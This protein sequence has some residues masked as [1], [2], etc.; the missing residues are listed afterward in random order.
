MWGQSAMGRVHAIR[1]QGFRKS[2]LSRMVN[3]TEQNIV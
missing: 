3:K 1:D 2:H